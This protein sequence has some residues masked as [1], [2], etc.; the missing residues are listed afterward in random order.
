MEMA[1]PTC[2]GPDGLDCSR[3][4]AWVLHAALLDHIEGVVA[5]DRSPDRAVEVLDRI[6][7]CD[8]LDPTDRRLVREALRGYL[9]DAPERDRAPGRAML[10][11]LGQSSSSQ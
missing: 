7:A 1:S 4:E 6:E 11:T 3:E 10:A 8:P 2:H 5:D 9:P